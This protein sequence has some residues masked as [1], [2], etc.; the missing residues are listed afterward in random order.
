MP[1][2]RAVGQRVVSQGL[3]R[4]LRPMLLT[5]SEWKLEEIKAPVILQSPVMKFGSD[6]A[7]KL[8]SSRWQRLL[9]INSILQHRHKT[10]IYHI[11]KKLWK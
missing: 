7:K 6:S 1:E 8:N 4:S 2:E 10:Y 11:A 9:C 5:E 3:S